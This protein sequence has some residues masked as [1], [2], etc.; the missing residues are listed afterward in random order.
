M[1]ITFYFCPD[2][3]SLVLSTIIACEFLK[4]RFIEKLFAA[5][6][7]TNLNFNNKFITE[8]EQR[9]NRET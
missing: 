1:F 4:D 2:M 6:K 8:D 3:S 5:C 9:R 7:I